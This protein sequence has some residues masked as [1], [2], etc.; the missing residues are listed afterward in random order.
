[1]NELTTLSNLFEKI[2]LRI[3]DYQRGYSW[4]QEQLTDF[5]ND[6]SNIFIRIEN[7][8]HF[9]GIVT[10][11][12]IKNDFL[13]KLIDEGF[14]LTDS[15]DLEILEET[16]KPFFIVDG[17]QRLVSILILML[18]LIEDLSEKDE[19]VKHIKQKYIVNESNNQKKY[20]FGYE[21]DTP[22]HQY[23]I[24]KIFSDS[25]MKIDE[26][27]TVYTKNLDN[28]KTF[29]TKRISE[30]SEH[31][32]NELLNII[33]NRLLF[34]VFEIDN[35]K[36]DMSLVFETL[37]YRGKKLTI[38]EL[39]KNR[40]IFLVTKKHIID[41]LVLKRIRQKIVSTWLD[42]Y[43]WLGKNEDYKLND[44]EF[45]R[46][47][48]L[49]YFNH[50]EKKE[51]D[52]KN[53][54]SD[55]FDDKYKISDIKDND[56]LTE[57]SLNLMLGTMS[58]AI[59]IWFFIHNPK[60][61]FD[62]NNFL[63]HLSAENKNVIQLINYNNYGSFMKILSL[64]AIYKNQID[65]DSTEEDINIMN[66]KIGK[67]LNEIERHN[68]C[69]YLLMGKKRDTNRADFY[70][71]F[72][73]YFRGLY[74]NERIINLIRTRT[75]SKNT[76][77]D[78]EMHIHNNHI[79]NKKFYDWNGIKYLLYNWEIFLQK[80]N[81]PI[82]KEYSKCELKLIF[83]EERGYAV[84]FPN[85][86]RSKYGEKLDYLRFSLGNITITNKSYN[87]SNYKTLH[88]LLKNG[89]YSDRDVH[90]NYLDWTDQTIFDRGKRI[91]EFISE[92][93]Q[94]GLSIQSE[95]KKLLVGPLQIDGKSK[96]EN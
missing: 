45:L 30:K 65:V 44:D 96:D 49:F 70:R 31:R 42:I 67:V 57:H 78:F 18:V 75:N 60:F 83:P 95:N 34:Y 68:F 50:D 48:W 80:S 54:N 33:Q 58:K 88:P 23:L 61:E 94:I 74:D 77:N 72:N 86:T 4:E 46:S 91:F 25:S 27:E 14:S 92:R 81:N 55:L 69:I 17:Q 13:L 7:S 82:I 28:A 89:S 37:N 26:P 12:K 1:M 85:V 32:K 63:K 21:K 16:Y 19:T 36:L 87:P 93:W 62:E 35:E 9:T 71:D 5:W 73:R 51:A 53:F 41:K 8:F 20:I 84:Q 15:N 22:S 56:L 3:P 10:L 38:L 90:V 6:L 24:G 40:L 2:V 43:E 11:E 39:F 29:F 47:F 79:N 64:C 76:Y 66:A 59:K 52:F